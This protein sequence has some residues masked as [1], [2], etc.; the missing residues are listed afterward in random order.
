M[1]TL[2]IILAAIAT[3]LAILYL[4]GLLIDIFD[5]SDREIE[6]ARV[7][8]ERRQAETKIN[9]LTSSA[10]QQLTEAAAPHGVFCQCARC[11]GRGGQP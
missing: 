5:E 9:R 10:I 6:I 2:V 4:V 8:R 3:I 1:T 7:N 11:V